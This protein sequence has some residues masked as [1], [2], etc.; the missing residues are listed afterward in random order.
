MAPELSCAVLSLGNQ[1]GLVDAVRS[2]LA[3][4]VPM[5]VVVVNSGGGDPEATL[6][7][8]GITVPVITRQERLYAGAARN[9]GIDATEAPYVGFLSGDCLL[10]P[11]WAEGALRRHREGTPAVSSAI[12]NAYPW[13]ACAQASYMLLFHTRMPGCAE[14]GRQLYGLSYDRSLFERYGRFRE[15]LRAGEDTELKERFGDE[16]GIAWAPDVRVA[17]RHPTGARALLRDQYRRGGRI[18][19]S[20]EAIYGKGA[21]R[22]VARNAPRNA[23]LCLST[24]WAATPRGERGRLVRAWP[25]IGPAAAAYA[26]GAL[27]AGSSIRSAGPQRR[28]QKRRRRRR[29]DS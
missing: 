6:R 15:D 26:L 7:A 8:A 29:P 1:P 10:E 2:V 21:G 20:L 3:Q 17:H 24:T 28:D 9:L 12:T 25:A 18:V 13:S 23:R 16:V 14:H 5:E 4:S 27:A 19:R 22:T 11:G